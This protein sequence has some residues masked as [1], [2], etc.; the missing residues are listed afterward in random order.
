MLTGIMIGIA[1]F[2]VSSTH[3]KWALLAFGLSVAFIL[4]LTILTIGD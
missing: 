2:N 3:P 4:D 1:A